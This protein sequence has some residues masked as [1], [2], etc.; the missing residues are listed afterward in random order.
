[1]YRAQPCLELCSISNQLLCAFSVL[2]GC[3]LLRFSLMG[4]FKQGTLGSESWI[5]FSLSCPPFL[6]R[7]MNTFKDVCDRKAVTN[8]LER[9]KMA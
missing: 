6:V 7:H 9:S 4:C 8:H 3:V 5:L 1:M 2:S